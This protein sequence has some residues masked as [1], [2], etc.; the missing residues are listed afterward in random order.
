MYCPRA[1]SASSFTAS[2]VDNGLGRRSATPTPWR[3]TRRV[4]AP[5]R[6]WRQSES[7]TTRP[8]RRTRR[9]SRRSPRPCSNATR[10]SGKPRPSIVNRSYYRCQ[11]LPWFAGR[12]IVDIGH[13]DVQRWFASHRATPVAADR[14]TPIL[15]VI[16][17]EAELMGY[18]P[19]GSNPCRGIRRYRRKGRERYLTDEEIR[20]LAARLSA[21][22]S[23]RPK[24]SRKQARPA[25]S[26]RVARAEVHYRER[27]AGLSHGR[28]APPRRHGHRSER[29][30]R[31]GQRPGGAGAMLG[32]IL[33][34]SRRGFPT[35]GGNTASLWHRRRCNLHHTI[36]PT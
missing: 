1:P 29:V 11:L 9:V 34:S 5:I 22:E 14:S 16:L 12:S 17:R 20:R 23:E 25:R 36:Q 28:E 27:H 2:T 4:H 8:W 35:D 3:W 21:N 10:T 31:T 30:V 13:Q 19:E 6:F 32:A 26:A 24:S 15:S 33:V 7:P 18:R